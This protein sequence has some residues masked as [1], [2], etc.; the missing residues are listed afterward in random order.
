MAN[1]SLC[2]TSLK[3]I[4]WIEKR[5]EVNAFILK[6]DLDPSKPKQMIGLVECSNCYAFHTL[7]H[8]RGNKGRLK[9]IE[10]IPVTEYSHTFVL[11]KG[12]IVRHGKGMGKMT[13][14]E[15]ESPS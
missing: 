1:C 7:V 2:K 8:E 10:T 15:T 4:K 3:N 5:Y 12:V 11:K 9:I 14:W 6:H 13:Q